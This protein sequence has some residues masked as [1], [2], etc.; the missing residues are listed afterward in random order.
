M[1]WVKVHEEKFTLG[2]IAAD[3]VYQVPLDETQ[4]KH[5]PFNNWE[6]VNQGGV[7]FGVRPNQ[8]SDKEEIVANGDYR[9]DGILDGK[10]SVQYTSLELVNRSSSTASTANKVFLICRKFEWREE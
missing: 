9:G 4:K 1:V 2:S 10:D 7:E 5:W 8:D 6:V 3:G